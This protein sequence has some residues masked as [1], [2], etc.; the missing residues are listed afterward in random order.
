MIRNHLRIALRKF[1]KDR[2]FTLLNLIGLA[3]GLACTFLIYLWVNDEMSMDKFHQNKDRLFQVLQNLPEADGVVAT[4]EP[5]P[6]ILAKT[7]A[8]EMPEVEEAATVRVPS[9]QENPTGVVS[10]NDIHIKAREQ[11]VTPNYFRMFSYQLLQGNKDKVLSGKYNVLLSDDLAMRL[12]HTTENLVGKTVEWDRSDPFSRKT[13]GSF[14]IS[15]IFKAPPSTSSTQFD[16]LFTYDLYFEKNKSYLDNWG[17]SN[18]KTF[19]LLKKGVDEKAFADKVWN[20]YREK[21]KAS[22]GDED[23]QYI[24]TFLLQRYSDKYLHNAYAL[25]KPA[26]G[27]IEYVKLFTIIAI[28]ILV[29]ACINFMNLSTARASGRLKEVGIRKVVG[30][31]R[32]MLILQHLGESLLMAFLSLVIAAVFVWIFLPTFKNITGKDLNLHITTNLV[33]TILSITCVTGLIAGSYPAI[34]LSSFRPTAVLKGKLQTSSGESWIRKVLVIFQFSISAM[35]I[36]SVLVVYTQ[37]KLI[38][39]KNLGLNKENVIRFA[40]AGKIQENQSAFLAEIKNIPGVVNA[41]AMSGDMLGTHASG[42]GISWPGKS[43]NENVE[44]SGI[45]SDYGLI[46]TLGIKMAAGRPFSTKFGSDSDQVIFNESAIAAMHLKDPVGKTVKL[47]GAEKQIVGVVKDFHFESLYKKIGP[48]F[49]TCS[50]N[51]SSILVK[52]QAFN[53]HET[54]ARIEKFYKEFNQGLPFEYRFL[55]DDYQAHYASEQRVSVLSRYFAGMAIII[56]CLGLFGLAAFTAQKREKEIG[57][58]KVVGASVSSVIM[59]LSKDFLKLVLIAL[60]IAF[61]LSWLFMHRW[62][63]GFAYRVPI[64]VSIFLLAGSSII[65]ITLLTISFQ[66]VKSA[67]MNPVNSLRSE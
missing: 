31:S 49:I 5:T 58:R 60:L 40:N 55:D 9:P 33:I 39:T 28:F 21:W 14:I 10:V 42:G 8:D 7:L 44:F 25:G 20:L 30:A 38:Q 24:G 11:Y 66:S 64:N 56:S 35:L 43:P 46:E 57:I 51:N 23:L 52:I 2:R 50:Q 22:H 65:L 17:S 19:V 3:T 41:A 29:I 36:I 18:P 13:N 37:M 4:I 62:L 54:I 1:Y 59:L 48:L 32:R 47:W 34:Y 6:G 26:G 53:E 61:P 63:E 67:M 15:G 27:R 16:I 12:F 45:Y